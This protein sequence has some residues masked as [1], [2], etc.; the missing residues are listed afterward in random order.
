MP[1]YNTDAT[2]VERYRSSCFASGM[3][4]PSGVKSAGAPNE[5]GPFH[6]LI[7]FEQYTACPRAHLLRP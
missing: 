6:R 1:I 4:N 2:F 7:Y 5:Q 3:T